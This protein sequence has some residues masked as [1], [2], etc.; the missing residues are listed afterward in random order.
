MKHYL[1]G[2]AENVSRETLKVLKANYLRDVLRGMKRGKD[3][4]REGN[5]NVS[6]ETFLERDE[7]EIM[8]KAAF[9]DVDGTLLSYKTGIVPESTKRSLR[10]LREK[11]IKIYIATGR[12]SSE[13]VNMPDM[14]VGFDGYITLNGQLCLDEKMEY[15]YGKPFEKEIVEELVEIFEEKKIPIALVEEKEVYINMVN[16]AVKKA[17]YTVALDLPDIKEYRNAPLYQAIVYIDKEVELDLANRLPKGCK[18]TR[19]SDD[20]ID[21]ISDV[22]GKSNG[23]RA[24]CEKLGIEKDEIM[25]FGDADNDI[26][27]IEHAGI[28]VVMGNAKEHIKKIGDYVTDEVDE[29]GIEKALIHFGIL[30]EE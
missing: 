29:D 22:G 13:M 18:I 4:R 9:F 8:I 19:W 5:E 1:E 30:G 23:I 14:G 25:A 21:I 27:M 20:G 6:R 15:F 11:G 10:R 3:F 12:H 24:I 28:G 2:K 26:D 16:E 7:G 17:Q